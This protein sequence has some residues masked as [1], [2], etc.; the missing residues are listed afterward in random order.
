MM[1]ATEVAVE[2]LRWAAAVFA[3]LAFYYS[4]SFMWHYRKVD[5]RE[6]PWGWHVMR[7]LIAV[8][9][10]TAVVLRILAILEF[11]NPL[12]TAA[13]AVVIYGW[14]AYEMRRRVNLEEE[15]Q[16]LYHRHH[17]LSKELSDD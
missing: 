2:V 10:A 4:V 17:T 3:A 14:V 9:M 15:A 12:A 5:W 8:A 6:S 11:T 7:F 16:R 13:I 1:T